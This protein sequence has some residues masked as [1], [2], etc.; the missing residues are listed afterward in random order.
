[1]SA[2]DN[3]RSFDELLLAELLCARV[4]SSLD[5]V[6]RRYAT[7]SWSAARRRLFDATKEPRG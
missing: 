7:T 1:M 2:P 3:T 4:E 6:R 5:A